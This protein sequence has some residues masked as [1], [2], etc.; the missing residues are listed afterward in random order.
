LKRAAAIAALACALTGC[1][2][3][4]K[5]VVY[6]LA[7]RVGVADR[8]SSREVILFG[9]AAAEPHQ[10]DGFYRE[11]AAPAGDAFTWTKGHA[12]LSLSFDQPAA[13]TAV[14][15]LAPY[16]GVRGQAAEVSLNGRPVARLTLNDGRHR[17]RVPLPSEAQRAGDNRLRFE[18]AATA[19]PADTPGNPDRRQLAAAFYG[20]TVAEAADAGVEDLLARDAPRP[21]AVAEQGG[22]PAL[23]L[24]APSVVRY[25][26][27]IPP[28]AELRFTP[29]LHSA[30]RAAGAAVALRVTVETESDG[31][32]ELWSRVV[33]ARAAATADDEEVSLPLPG[34]TGDVAR[35]S[36]HAGA[37]PGARFAWAVWTAPRIV[38][39]GGAEANPLDPVPFADDD[40]ARAAGLRRDLKGM[41]VLL[42]VLD[43]ARARSVGAYGYGRATTPELDRLAAEG[44]LFE[45]AATP[46]VYTLGAMS[47]LWTSQYPDRH[48]AEVSYADRLPVDRL[49]LA[50][51]LG[52]QGVHTA[53]FVANPMAGDLFGFER[54]FAHFEKVY[55][56]FPELGSRGEAFRR[57][58]PAWLKQNASRRFFA[59]VH[60]R[61][62]H[63]PYDPG[64][65][66]DTQFGPDAPLGR[67][68][69]RDKTWYTDVNQG[70][71]RP[72]PEEVA[73]LR[74]L[75][76][77]NLAYA[78]REVGVL[79]RALEEAGLWDRTVVIVTA[80]HGEQLYEHGYISHSAQV[81]EESTQ[82]P[83]VVRLPGPQA[84]RGRRVGAL[85]DL[86]DLAPTILDVFG[87][88][89]SGRAAREFQG[90]SLLPVLA[91]APGRVAVVSRTVWERPVY[92]LRDA[93]YKYIHDTRTGRELLFDLEEDPA[94]SRPRQSEQPLR[95]AYYRQT[96]HDWMAR[97][98]RPAGGSAG[99]VPAGA[100]GVDPATCAQLKSLGYVHARCP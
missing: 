68:E 40:A 3:P 54:G 49:T 29:R 76:D 80:D 51:V 14:V 8:W 62:P 4:R 35:V 20:L 10:V 57:V 47:S 87:G 86:M 22:V 73:H 85:V 100:E 33:D 41:N 5:T 58:L 45:R 69:R 82:V 25:A 71:V 96:L 44:A 11:A 83:L 64:P 95:T 92:G 46:A 89:A 91:G 65:P 90:R 2:S 23:V 36:F 77:G 74:R 6:D 81:Y 26:L 27:R 1:P 42:I 30:A 31:E 53:G 98:K 97:L 67:T 75:Y 34:R 19:S 18:F 17:Y 72:T 21:F 94:E 16:R 52:E 38:G 48:H 79:R 28:G 93:R 43:A 78:D 39:R 32:K 50:E 55:E 15:D 59:Y 37:A 99:A 7:R 66:F 13:R 60:L 12:E 88:A 56:L 9:T 84:P 61:E 24:V 63:F 70:R